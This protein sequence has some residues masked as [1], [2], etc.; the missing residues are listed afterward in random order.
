MSTIE[1]S[2]TAGREIK[3]MKGWKTTG[4]G[5]IFCG[6]YFVELGKNHD[7]GLIHWSVSKKQ[8]KALTS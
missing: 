7:D 3:A 8:M 6:K 1:I 2:V 5:G 4:Y